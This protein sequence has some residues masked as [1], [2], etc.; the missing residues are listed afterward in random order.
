V[1]TAWLAEQKMLAWE[2]AYR[3]MRAKYTVRLPRPPENA[4]GAPAPV[5][6]AVSGSSNGGV[7]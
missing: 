7:K 2:N 1:K 5:T 4:N 3:E 6:A